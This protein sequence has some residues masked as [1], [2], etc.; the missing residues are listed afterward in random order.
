MRRWLKRLG[1]ALLA[2]LVL[3]L[4]TP[5]LLPPFLDRVYYTGPKSAHFDGQRFFNPDE[6]KGGAPKYFNPARILRFV[7]GGERTPWPRHVPVQPAHPPRKVTGDTMRVTWI[8]HATVLIQTQGLNILTDPI[9]SERASPFPWFGPLRVREPGV[10]F[11]DL[12]KIDLVLVSHNHY[13]HMDLPTL[14]RLWSRDRPLIV[15]S[16]GNDTILGWHGI[17]AIA[18]DWGQSVAVKPGVAV[19]LDRVHHWGTRWG[20]DRSRALWSGF[21]ITMPHG[22]NVFFAGD[23]G[24][25]DM[26]WPLEAKAHGPIRFAM[27]PIGPERPRAMMHPNHVDG[28]DAVRVFTLLG[29]KS[30]LAIHWGTFQLGA[31]GIDE[32]VDSMHRAEAAQGVD[33]QRFRTTGAGQAWLVPKVR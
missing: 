17:T 5:I 32:P 25:G 14:E 19:I 10:R 18:R 2:L 33:P 7:T 8:G 31:D 24:P 4:L 3:L 26:R 9:F 13:D 21:T 28:A 12:P 27:I 29:A 30:A 15:T 11:E 16:L 1:G 23:T 6:P 20:K 22:G